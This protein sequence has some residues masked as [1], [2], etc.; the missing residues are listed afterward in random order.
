MAAHEI[1]H[2]L[3]EN[4]FGMVAVLFFDASAAAFTLA[5]ARFL[6]SFF[7][8]FTAYFSLNLKPRQARTLRCVN[9]A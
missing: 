3:T 5:C 6:A 4:G 2:S 9:T 7:S 1:A 8:S